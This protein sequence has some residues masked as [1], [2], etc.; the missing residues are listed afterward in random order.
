[1]KSIYAYTFIYAVGALT[2]LLL[3]AVFAA[4]GYAIGYL[5]DNTTAGVMCGI[6]WYCFNTFQSRELL[7]DQLDAQA[8]K[9]IKAL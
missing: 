3:T 1:V 4:V 9:M 6:A 5:F 7:F 2:V 8:E